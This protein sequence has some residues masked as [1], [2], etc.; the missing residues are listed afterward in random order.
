MEH[1]ST[2]AALILMA[3]GYTDV[4]PLEDGMNA[5]RDLG[6]PLVKKEGD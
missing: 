1:S 2:R 3:H 6:Y 4:H 5:W